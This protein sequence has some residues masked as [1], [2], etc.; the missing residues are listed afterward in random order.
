[1]RFTGRSHT[2]VT[3]RL[4][5]QQCGDTLHWDAD[6]TAPFSVA[7]FLTLHAMFCCAH[8]LSFAN[9]RAE[10]KLNTK[11]TPHCFHPEVCFFFFEN[12]VKNLLG[13][14][15]RFLG[16]IFG[17]RKAHGKT[18]LKTEK[19]GVNLT[20]IFTGFPNKSPKPPSYPHAG[21]TRRFW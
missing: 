13:A 5:F 11:A 2:R 12:H 9:S 3:V 18:H 15:S 8:H 16:R 21:R 6:V 14:N 10:T 19:L 20:S 7:H 17:Y 4:P 1:M